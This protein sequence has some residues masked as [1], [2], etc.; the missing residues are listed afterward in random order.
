MSKETKTTN[1]EQRCPICDS[2]SIKDTGLG[3][4]Y[5]HL[6]VKWN[7]KCKECGVDFSILHEHPKKGE[8]QEE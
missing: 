3:V 4:V 7:Y 1:S 5:D 8:P 6:T 2:T